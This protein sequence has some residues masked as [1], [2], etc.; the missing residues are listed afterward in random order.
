MA[1]DRS[2]EAELATELERVLQNGDLPD[3]A[4][5]RMRFSPDPA[6]LPVITVTP[7]QLGSYEALIGTEQMVE[8]H[9]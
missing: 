2:C 3:L 5:L 1:H 9:V 4:D 7:V 8:A 6:C